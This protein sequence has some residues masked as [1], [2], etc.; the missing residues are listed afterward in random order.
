MIEHMY[1]YICRYKGKEIKVQ[2]DTTY[3]AQEEAKRQFKCKNGWEIITM[4][5]EKDGMVVQHS[6]GILG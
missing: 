3:Q 6:P 5:S 4:L 1:T 2:A